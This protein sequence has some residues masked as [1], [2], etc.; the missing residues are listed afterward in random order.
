MQ[1]NPIWFLGG[2]F[3][4]RRDRQPIA[5]F[6]GF[7]GGSDGKE[8]T[9]NVGDLH[10]TPGLGRSPGG[11]HG[12]PLEYSCLENPNG[13][14]NLASYSPWGHRVRLDWS[15]KHTTKKDLLYSTE[16]SAECYVP[17]WM[18]GEFGGEWIY[19][20]VRLSPFTVHLK[21]S[22]TLLNSYTPTK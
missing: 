2:K 5:V 10:L 12:N 3:P 4:W 15:T 13:Q 17:A 9:C 20:Y 14:R 1:E 6:L 19:V 18:G 16:N 7:P 22:Q 21:I 8:S 11:G